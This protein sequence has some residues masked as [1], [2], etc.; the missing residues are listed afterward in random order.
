[1]ITIS[2]SEG[3]YLTNG[4]IYTNGELHLPAETDACA[5]YEVDSVA[6]DDSVEM[7]AEE[8]MGFLFGTFSI[9]KGTA[10]VKKETLDTIETL[11]GL[12]TKT[13]QSDKVG[14][15]WRNTYIG[16]TLIKQEYVEQETPMGTA[17]NPIVY[18]DGMT[19]INNAYYLKD[20]KIYV[21]MEEWV[22]ME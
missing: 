1:M 7:T 12:T 5:W 4:T 3:K 10:K 2:P 11:G 19:L 8:A 15:D 14:F 6:N 16:D 13:L 17:D 9:T 20:G 21:W 22:A 18:V